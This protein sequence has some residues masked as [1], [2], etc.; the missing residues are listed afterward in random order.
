MPGAQ[1]PS[2]VIPFGPFEADLHAQELRKLGVHLRLPRQSF[3]ILKML[4]QHPG[5][6]VTREEMR[7]ALWPS[8]TFVDFEHGLNAAINR[9][10]EALGDDANKPRYIETLPRRGYR[11]IAPVTQSGH[12]Q[13]TVTVT[14]KK[15]IATAGRARWQKLLF[16][17]VPAIALCAVLAAAVYWI[18][19]SLR[20]PRVLAYHQ[21]TKDR[22]PKGPACLFGSAIVTD[23]P[24]IFFAEPNMAVAQMSS[25]GGEVASV[26]VPFTT[27]FFFS[28]S[29]PDKSQLL[30][31]TF[32]NGCAMDQD[33]WSLSTATGLA[34]RL[35]DLTGHAGAWSPDGKTIAYAT[36]LN[37]RDG[38]DIYMA[39][40]DGSDVRKLTRIE[41]GIVIFMRWSPDGTILR[42]S[43]TSKSCCAVWEVASDGKNLR[44]LNL[45]PSPDY[46]A[47]HFNWTP[48]GKYFLSDAW[49]GP[50]TSEIWALR[51]KKFSHFWAP[52]K[53]VR[54]TSG[55]TSFWFP[56]PSANGGR[57]F[58]VGG[59]PR[60]ELVR[61][62]LKSHHF[63][64]YLSG[65]SADQLDFSPDG[66]WAAYV[67]F[68]EAVLWRSRIDG[69]ERMQLTTS[70]LIAA[71]P[72]WSPDGKGIAFSG[73][74]PKG[75]F[76]LYVIS[77]DGGKPVLVSGG[78]EDEL[79]A[80][81]A[82]DGQSLIFGGPLAST[83]AHISSLD[84]RTGRVSII[85]GSEGLFSPRSSPDGRFIVATDT[86]RRVKEYLFD[87]RTQK[88]S[89]LFEALNVGLQIWSKDSK[90]VYIWASGPH[91]WDLYRVRLA[92]QK[93]EKLAVLDI[94]QGTTGNWGGWAGLTPDG[95]P[96]VLRDFSIQEIYALDVDLP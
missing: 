46:A 60:G 77:A 94:P 36:N 47:L 35:G 10:R 43:V 45:F 5:E 86:S 66:K 75:V 83:H 26:P 62:D 12:M 68:P 89:E 53:P 72:R 14:D 19:M 16:I 49:T 64:P 34:Q 58:A 18:R 29:S 78:D 40:I 56:S 92:N 76:K 54:L 1:T 42:M 51:E 57:I 69:S 22:N 6:L 23:G 13:V 17:T 70:P 63:E 21:L 90:Y 87:Q 20:Q 39:A 38:N 7:S 33:F 11:F 2:T 32:S 27:G 79:D 30:G 24:R 3:Q 82:P 37:Q 25:T 73:S 84:L 95:S 67:T 96:Y 31:S 81:W 4:L 61:Y 48:D 93:S 71:V 88:W 85:P 50:S 55:A 9:L 28:D 15:N 52:S 41:N 74:L 91:R 65:I 8:D 59:Q 44:Q 80:T